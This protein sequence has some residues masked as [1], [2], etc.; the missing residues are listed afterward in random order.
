M[1]RRH[2]FSLL[3]LGIVLGVAVI[4]L[5]ALAATMKGANQSARSQRT[6]DE[7]FAISRSAAAAL[8]RNLVIDRVNP[9]L[10]R[11]RPTGAAASVPITN[12]AP[13]C[14]DLSRAPNAAATCP[15]SGAPGAAW[16][17]LAY[18]ATVSPV[19]NGSPLLSMF[20]GG[21]T[22]YGGGFN[23]WCEPYVVCLYPGRAE[24]LTCV[25][26]DDLG[27]AGFAGTV[28]C[29][30]CTAPS[31]VTGEVTRCIMAS[32]PVFNRSSGQFKYSYAA[33]D[34]TTVQTLPPIF[35]DNPMRP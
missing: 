16:S 26:M 12:A 17:N 30:D 6:G 28:Q 27:S 34:P 21:S 33:D 3:E 25:P 2:G 13:L 11:F 31:P 5:T 14:Y 24:V 22:V 20:G 32:T 1:R 10:F 23:A 8:K 7:L 19:P 29:G 18:F 15:S 35:S 9:G 4:L